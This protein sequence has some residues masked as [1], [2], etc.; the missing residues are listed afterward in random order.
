MSREIV[1]PIGMEEVKNEIKRICTNARIYRHNNKR[2]GPYIIFMDE[3]E[4]ITTLLNYVEDEMLENEVI[5]FSYVLDMTLEMRFETDLKPFELDRTGAIYSSDYS[6]IEAHILTEEFAKIYFSSQYEEYISKIKRIARKA[7]LLIFVPR[8]PSKNMKELIEKINREVMGIEKGDEITSYLMVPEY[9]SI[10]LAQIISRRIE[11]D[12]II[13]ENREA[14]E[15]TL[16][17]LIESKDINRVKGANIVA[18]RLEY[19]AD[20]GDYSS[21]INEMAIRKAY[22]NPNIMEEKK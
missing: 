11:D 9:S 12:G 3:G 20:Y 19:Y 5:D 21:T 18:D 14:F 4:G 6:G 13:I 7:M 8:N 15:N 16:L 2:P 10:Q 1:A 22:I 17:D